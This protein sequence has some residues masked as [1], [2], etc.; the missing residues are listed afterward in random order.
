MTNYWH[1][2]FAFHRCSS[3]C[4]STSRET[5]FSAEYS[6]CCWA[7][8]LE[9]T[10][11]PRPTCWVRLPCNCVTPPNYLKCIISDYFRVNFQF[12][13]CHPRDSKEALMNTQERMDPVAFNCWKYICYFIIMRSG[14][15]HFEGSLFRS[16]NECVSP[17]TLPLYALNLC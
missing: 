12:S 17:N 8:I 2:G 7:I 10:K 6:N 9:S 16:W 4:L 3:R 11:K 15:L 13:A 14:S 5:D 1:W